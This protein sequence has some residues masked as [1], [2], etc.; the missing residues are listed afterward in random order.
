MKTE[1]EK[2]EKT[3][4]GHW[5]VTILFRNGK[6]YYATTTDSE[7]IDNFK[8]EWFTNKD[9]KDIAY[10]KRCLINC[11]KSANNLN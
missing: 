8:K 9:L 5:K 6:N 11:V 3:G 2:I 1:I 7:S 10:A 4:Y